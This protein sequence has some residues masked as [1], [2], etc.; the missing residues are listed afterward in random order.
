MGETKTENQSGL[1]FVLV[2]PGGVGKN[3]LMN[4]V[5]ARIDRLR[6]LPTATTRPMR[7]NEQQGREHHFMD[8]AAFRAMIARGDL[9][10]HQEVTPGR[11]YGVPRATV[12]DAIRAGQDQIADIDYLGARILRRE[13][14]LSTVLVFIA[15]PSMATLEAQMRERG[16][17]E[18]VIRERM[19]RAEEEM[20]F[21]PECDYL[22]INDDLDTAV[23]MLYELVTLRQAARSAEDAEGFLPLEGYAAHRASLDYTVRLLPMTRDGG[24]ARVLIRAE[25]GPLTENLTRSQPPAHL[26]HTLL[27]SV[28]GMA[29]AERAKLVLVPD[30][31]LPPV[32]VTYEAL[33][34]AYALTYT[35]IYPVAEVPQPPGFVWR[36]VAEV[37]AVNANESM[38]TTES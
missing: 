6:Q 33:T 30:S 36:P 1:L 11:F 25:G 8:E 19:A 17:A 10:E 23:E 4:H 37:A 21:A 38:E 35:Y 32:A 18:S 31:L 34:G 22:I 26:A 12:A 9:L 29:G 5:L 2:G 14:P 27:E 24:E 28:P 13:H 3:T 15:P 20:A 7:A 16:T